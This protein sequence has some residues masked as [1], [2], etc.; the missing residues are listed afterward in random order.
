[1]M[2]GEEEDGQRRHGV[3]TFQEALTRANITSGAADDTAMDRRLSRQLLH[4]VPRLQSKVQQCITI[5][6]RLYKMAVY[7]S[8]P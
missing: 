6:A 7:K 4:I 8:A 1:M 5:K 2:A 3:R